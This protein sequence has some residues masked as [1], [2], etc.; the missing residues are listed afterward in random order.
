MHIS[1]PPPSIW[2]VPLGLRTAGKE[3]QGWL[4]GLRASEEA[5]KGSRR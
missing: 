4:V 2:G 1:K 5:D 3:D